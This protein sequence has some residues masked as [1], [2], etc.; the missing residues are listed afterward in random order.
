MAAISAD[1]LVYTENEQGITIEAYIGDAKQ[2]EIPNEINAQA[3]VQI[4]ADAFRS[5]DLQSVLIPGNVKMIGSHAF[6]D[7]QLELVI[8]QPMSVIFE[9]EN[10]FTDN[11]L[12]TLE[13]YDLPA[14]DQVKIGFGLE[15]VFDPLD[16]RCL[17]FALRL[18][19]A[20]DDVLDEFA[21]EPAAE[22]LI[23]K[24]VIDPALIQLTGLTFM[25][26][27]LNVISRVD[28]DAASILLPEAIDGVAID[29]ILSLG[30]A[31]IESLS[32]PDSYQYFGE[33]AFADQPNLKGIQFK[34]SENAAEALIIHL[35]SFDY[36][37]NL[38]VIEAD[39]SSA[40]IC[41]IDCL[42]MMRA[43]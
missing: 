9:A 12:K 19:D 8:L 37:P 34:A 32:I 10:V 4:A 2:I 39:A 36:S 35:N 26:R 17:G 38:A 3:V 30:D 23:F 24:E 18:H 11:P 33:N 29:G 42:F 15:A 28:S 13:V 20:S 27:K 25:D 6:A 14:Y 40:A 5:C 16:G 7:N 22:S 41:V 1:D 31:S 21:Y 43:N